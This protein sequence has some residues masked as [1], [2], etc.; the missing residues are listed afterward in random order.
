[1]GITVNGTAG[2]DTLQ[3]SAGNDSLIGW[4]GHDLLNGNAGADTLVG[5][6][7]NDTY[8]VDSATDRLTEFA[9]QG[10][11]VVRSTVSWQLAQHFENLTLW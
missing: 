5:G 9:N 4:A 11:D 8:G 3:G 1:M 7:G 10:T 6:L 2:N